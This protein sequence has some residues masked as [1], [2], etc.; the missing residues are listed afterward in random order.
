M[1][2]ILLLGATGLVGREC[3]EIALSHDDVTK[4][5]A[6][7]RRPLESHPKLVNPVSPT[8]EALLGDVAGWATESVICALGTT[9]KKAGSDK[10]LRRVDYEVPLAFA[11]ATRNAGAT[12]FAV[13][14][15]IGASPSSSL[16]YARTK[17]ELERDLRTLGFPSLTIL[18]PMFIDGPRAESRRGEETVIALA[19]TL[20]PLLPR[21]LRVSPVKT[22][23]RELV[24]SVSEPRAGIRVI[25]SRDLA[26]SVPGRT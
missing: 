22:I 19:K 23:A 9:R 3:L 15:S 8:L 10:E 16:F 24:S 20:A 18:R 11:R 2:N 13:V 21:S 7:T 17:G 5:V 14:T 12:S 26:A 25:S 6:P 1:T 4:I